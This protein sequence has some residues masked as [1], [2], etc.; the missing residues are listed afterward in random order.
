MSPKLNCYSFWMSATNGPVAHGSLYFKL[1][2]DAR[3][4]T[5]LEAKE[6]LFERCMAALAFGSCPFQIFSKLFQ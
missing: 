2:L 6:L 4:F 5:H 1:I 3:S